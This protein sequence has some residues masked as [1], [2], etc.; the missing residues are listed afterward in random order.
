MARRG[1]PRKAGKRKENGKLERDNYAVPAYDHGT[2]RAQ[3][4]FRRFGTHGATALGRAYASGLL[5]DE[6]E[7]SI[8]YDAGKRF[9]RLY[10]ALIEQGRY[11]CPLARE[12]LS[13]GV[14]VH[15]TGH[16]QDEADQAWLFEAMDRLDHAGLRPWLDQLVLELYADQG[17]YW[18][19]AILDGG[20]DPVDRM[21][22]KWAVA[23][24]DMIAPETKAMGIRVVRG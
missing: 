5:G 10:S 1:R 24:L 3:E 18:L 12:R 6:Q 4:R 7:A 8:R 16:R 13:A 2:E 22:L 11:R 23:A 19:D 14:V 17:P 21:V 9:S 15:F 20:R